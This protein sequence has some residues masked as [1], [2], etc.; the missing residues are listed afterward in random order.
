MCGVEWEERRCVRRLVASIMQYLMIA[1]RGDTEGG[2]TD[3]FVCD[4]GI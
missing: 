3:Y 1:I 4:D 2:K